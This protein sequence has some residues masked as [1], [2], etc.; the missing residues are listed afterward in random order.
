[1]DYTLPVYTDLTIS[2]K[3]D[4]SLKRYFNSIKRNLPKGWQIEKRDYED[5]DT[6]RIL[7]D[8]Y[9]IRTHKFVDKRKDVIVEGFIDIGLTND[10]IIILKTELNLDIPK[11]ESLEFIG[12]IVHS[13]H[14]LVL[15]VNKHYKSFHH[16]FIFGGP[17]D[18]N[19]FKKDYRDERSIKIFSK[20]ENATFFLSE[21]LTIELNNEKFCYSAP[22]NISLSLSLMKKSLKRGLFFHDKLSKYKKDNSEDKFKSELYDYFEEIQTS[23][24]FSYISVEAFSNAAIPDNYIYE[25]INDK[26]IKEMWN[27]ENI[28]RWMSTSEKVG[29]ILQEILNSTSI[30]SQPFW[31]S[32]RDLEKLRNDIVH[33]K[34]IKLG[35]ELDSEIFNQMLSPSIFEKIESSLKVIE[36][37][38]KLD[39]SHPF[40]PLGLGVAQYQL[41]EIESM[42]KH[43]KN[44]EDE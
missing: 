36:F 32:F 33:Q 2:P 30:K 23:I 10:T 29:D 12:Y 22:N 1:M 7:K 18:E 3:L 39:N 26:G 9:C 38:Y 28:E 4:I 13:F 19:W 27:K 24:I 37:F 40:F 21:Q 8:N 34:T 16:H 42:E 17:L 11:E 5:I 20:A 15:K 41:I 25:K 43:F 14:E 35:K 6:F 31:A 44:L